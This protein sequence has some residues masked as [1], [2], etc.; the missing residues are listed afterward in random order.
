MFFFFV[1]LPISQFFDIRIYDAPNPIGELLGI[2]YCS[3]KEND[4][5]V[6]RQH[7]NDLFPYYTSLIY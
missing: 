6:F 7:N 1:R 3:G 2:W 5:D 4:I